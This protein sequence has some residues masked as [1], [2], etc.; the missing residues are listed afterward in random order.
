PSVSALGQAQ[1]NPLP[2]RLLWVLSR[3]RPSQAKGN[4]PA[5]I[6]A[7]HRKLFASVIEPKNLVI[8]VQQRDNGLDSM[9]SWDPIAHLSIDLGVRIQVLVAIGALDSAVGAVLELIG[10]NISVVV[11]EAHAGRDTFLVVGE[12]EVPVVGRLPQQRG[13]VSASKAVREI[14]A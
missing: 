1:R 11:G 10:K 7:L 12:I 5:V 9:R 3:G 8:Q 14:G 6:L 2:N 4:S 13:M